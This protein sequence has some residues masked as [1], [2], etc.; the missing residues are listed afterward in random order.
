[1]T[2][3]DTETLLMGLCDWNAIIWVKVKAGYI[4]A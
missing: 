2:S 1:M 3:G 4:Q